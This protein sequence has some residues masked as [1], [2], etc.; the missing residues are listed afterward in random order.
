M[1]YFCWNDNLS[2]PSYQKHTVLYVVIYQSTS[3]VTSNMLTPFFKNPGFNSTSFARLKTVFAQNYRTTVGS[4]TVLCIHNGYLKSIL[5]RFSHASLI[6]YMSPPPVVWSGA[7]V[8]HF[9]AK[10]LLYML[11]CFWIFLTWWTFVLCYWF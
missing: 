8:S 2:H 4:E 10:D 3:K 11:T 7:V 9:F 5:E 6:C 1:N